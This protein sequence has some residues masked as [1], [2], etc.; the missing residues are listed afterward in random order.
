VGFFPYE[1]SEFTVAVQLCRSSSFSFF[2]FF[3]SLPLQFS[4]HP[5]VLRALVTPFG[6][7]MLL[8]CDVSGYFLLMVMMSV[9]ISK[10]WVLIYER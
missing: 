10:Q 9:A 4:F 2:F 1:H 3:F 5:P 8:A 7:P 6:E